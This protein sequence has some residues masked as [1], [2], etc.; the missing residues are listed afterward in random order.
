MSFVKH[1][2]NAELHYTEELVSY[3]VHSL[4][5]YNTPNL[6]VSETMAKLRFITALQILQ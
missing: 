2:V 1:F 3:C 4:L 5:F 6:N